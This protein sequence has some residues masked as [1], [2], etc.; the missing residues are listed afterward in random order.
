MVDI[1]RSLEKQNGE[2]GKAH[3]VCL[4]DVMRVADRA[5]ADPIERRV[6][7][8]DIWRPGRSTHQRLRRLCRGQQA[9]GQN[10]RE[11]MY[12]VLTVETSLIWFISR[13]Y[14][15]G[16][17]L[18]EDFLARTSMPRCTDFRDTAEVIS[19]VSLNISPIFC[20]SPD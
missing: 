5:L 19:K 2:S 16:T 14:N 1:G 10:V 20:R 15:I 12:L 11:M 18:I 3:S 8:S 6:V 17:R 9:A 13:G 4:L 7:Q